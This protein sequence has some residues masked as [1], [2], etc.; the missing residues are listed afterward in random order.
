[1]LHD[2]ETIDGRWHPLDH[3]AGKVPVRS[4]FH[5]EGRSPHIFNK[6]AEADCAELQTV[7]RQ[8][9]KRPWRYMCT[10]HDM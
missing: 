7:F 9:P 4:G 3:S 8:C 5:T 10:P 2:S 1:M 6:R